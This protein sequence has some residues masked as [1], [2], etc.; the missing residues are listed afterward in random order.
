MKWKVGPIEVTYDEEKA[1]TTVADAPLNTEEVFRLQAVLRSL[2]NHQN[3]RK[4][5]AAE[6][7]ALRSLGLDRLH[8]IR[9]QE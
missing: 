2:Y 5:Q 7:E 8:R 4:Q 6:D 9:P 1:T 3:R